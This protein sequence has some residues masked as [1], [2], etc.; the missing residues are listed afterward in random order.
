[1][2]RISNYL[3]VQEGGKHVEARNAIGAR[4]LEYIQGIHHIKSFG[5]TSAR[6][7]SLDQALNDF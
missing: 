5:M 3:I 4:F 1:M 6:F 2:I 7:G